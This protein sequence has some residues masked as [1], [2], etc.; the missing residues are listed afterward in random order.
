MNIND[1]WIIKEPCATPPAVPGP[2]HGPNGKIDPRYLVR[3]GMPPYEH[4]GP[5]C[6]DMNPIPSNP[7][8]PGCPNPVPNKWHYHVPPARPSFP[9][10]RFVLK[11]QLN[12]ILKSIAEAD[13][14]VDKSKE[15]TTVKVGGIAAGTKLD[16]MTFSEFIE[17]LLYSE[18]KEGEPEDPEA[19][20]R[21]SD[22]DNYVKGSELTT[23]LGDYVTDAVLML[24][25]DDYVE[26]C[27]LDE[28]VKSSDVAEAINTALE[29]FVT[30]EDFN[31]KLEEYAKKEEV[32]TALGGY[33]KTS[34][35]ATI[36]ADYAKSTDVET[37]A[38]EAIEKIKSIL[39][40]DYVNSAE[41][42]ISLSD[43][44]LKT[45]AENYVTEAELATTLTDYPTTETIEN[46]MKYP[47]TGRNTK[48]V[49]AIGAFQIGDDISGMNIID[50]I[51]K[52]LCT[53]TDPGP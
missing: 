19:Y 52:M 13:I 27:D 51:E 11:K 34:A 31:T 38:D 20:V 45:D 36:L 32:D 10:D 33:V 47:S 44:V 18:I 49:N 40:D 48:V 12:Q 7:Y 25:L 22:L 39:K 43:Y 16:K 26:K 3:P 21:F 37:A 29:D 4:P 46:T 30:S 15:G 28:Y 42:Y 6:Y 8:E 1:D 35:L 53:Q 9:E 2:S 14:F 23:T 17:K 5:C 41:L 24:L 50:I